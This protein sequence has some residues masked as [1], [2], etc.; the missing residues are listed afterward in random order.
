MQKFYDIFVH[1]IFPSSEDQAKA[2]SEH[3]AELCTSVTRL[4]VT[5]KAVSPGEGTG[6]IN[7]SKEGIFGNTICYKIRFYLIKKLKEF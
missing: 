6:Q 5:A 3:G 7:N 1:C 4:L 2:M